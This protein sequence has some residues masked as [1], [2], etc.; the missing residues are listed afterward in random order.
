MRDIFDAIR[1]ACREVSRG[2]GHV[3]IEHDRLSDY[4]ARLPLGELDTPSADPGRERHGDDEQTASFVVTLDTVNFG[5]GFFPHLRKRPGLSGYFTIATALRDHVEAQGAFTSA[6]LRALTAADCAQIFGQQHRDAVARE[7]MAR[8]A[9]ALND[10]GRE[11]DLHHGGSFTTLVRSADCSAARLVSILDRLADFHDVS[12]WR[13]IEV[14]LYKRAQITAFDLAQ[15]FG[16]T[17]LG[18]FDDLHRLTMFADNLVPHV[19]R[20]DGVLVFDPALVAR[21]ERGEDI[22]AGTEPEVEIRAVAVHAVELLGDHLRAGGRPVT[23]GQLD[24][25]LWT[26]GGGPAYNAVRR[27]RTRTSFY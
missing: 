8:F 17:G 27:H 3:R 2:A 18:R 6:R 24:S 25:V 5:S 12:R 4:A 14:P 26:R 23:S 1:H 21:I 15:A 16:G 7:L 19:L 22:G 10:L 11:L 9:A 20:V 13:G